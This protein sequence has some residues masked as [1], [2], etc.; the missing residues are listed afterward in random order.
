MLEDFR[1]AVFITFAFRRERLHYLFQVLRSLGEFPVTRMDVIVFTNTVDTDAIE[2]IQ[3]FRANTFD[4]LKSLQ[5]VSVDDLEHPF[6]LTW[7]HK[8]YLK[9]CL[10][11]QQ[12]DFT[13]FIYME[14]DLRFTYSN[15]QYFVCSEQELRQHGLIP[16]FVR[17]EYN[18]SR[19]TICLSD[20]MHPQRM[21]GKKHVDLHGVSFMNSD[22]PYIA[23]FVM[24]RSHAEE[25][26]SN[27]S[28]DKEGSAGSHGWWIAERAAMGITWDNVPTGYTSRY[29]IGFRDNLPVPQAYIHH[30][31]DNYTNDYSEQRKMLAKLTPGEAFQR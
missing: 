31:P 24:T 11:D 2:S 29:V 27:P 9:Q 22:Y 19:A 17:F 8:P 1:I 21:A 18:Q 14:D 15:F 25:H 5:I 4:E 28:F 7:A 10:R 12:K 6:D 3:A 26:L 20:H 16:S 30:M 23:M 13:H